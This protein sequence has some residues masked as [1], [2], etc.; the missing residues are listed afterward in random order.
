MTIQ[1]TI[2]GV[3]KKL[4]IAPGEKLLTVLRRE[5]YLGVKFGCGRGECG[6][7]TVIL[8]GKAVQSCLTFAAQ[9]H[10]KEVVTVEGIGQPGHLHPIQE[11]ILD[12][13]AVQCGYCTPGIVCLAKAFLDENP[14]PTEE[15][16]RD[17]LKGNLCRCTGYI[18][19]VEAILDAAERLRA[20]SGGSA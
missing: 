13:G 16:V 10:Q 11:A 15:Q 17:A 4:D 5:G 1:V 18:K 20:A 3:T 6:V 2:N 19:Y 8:D 9:A 12:H 7:C 14:H